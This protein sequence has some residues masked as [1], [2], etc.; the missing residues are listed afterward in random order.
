MLLRPNHQHP[1]E[2]PVPVRNY[3]EQLVFDYIDQHLLGSFNDEELQDIACLALNHLPPRYI[4]HQVDLTFY[5]SPGEH[6]EM[7]Q[8]V[9]NAITLARKRV[10]GEE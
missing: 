3:Y 1:V 7:E 5:M 2:S 4:R 6:K 9:E 8:R 10:T